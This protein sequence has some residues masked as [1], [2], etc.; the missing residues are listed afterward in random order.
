MA[1][2]EYP[3]PVLYEN[4]DDYC[5]GCSFS[6][7]VDPEKQSVEGS[8]IRLALSYNLECPGLA[9]MISDGEAD[10]CVLLHSPATS[11]RRI[12]PFGKSETDISI[13]IQKFDVA[14]KIEIRGVILSTGE[15]ENFMLEDFNQDF[16]GGIPP[17]HL[18][19]GDILAIA[20]RFILYLDDTDLEKPIESIFHVN[21]RE[22]Q[23]VQIVPTFDNWETQKIEVDVNPDVFNL[24]SNIGTSYKKSTQRILL[25]DVI[26]PVLVEGI[27]LLRYSPDDYEGI[28]WART[29]DKKLKRAGVE[30]IANTDISSVVLANELLGGVVLDSLNEL[31]AVIETSSE[32]DEV[33]GG[34]D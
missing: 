10:A 21:L 12:F 3:N 14:D 30:D 8:E 5:E 22:D 7:S 1:A 2:T 25:N 31:K 6:L 29:I 34:V 33:Y 16:F 20:E 18:R 19:R 32:G 13:A 17:F 23:D 28:R 9:C 4:G 11:F 24:Y 26:L 27:T 15:N